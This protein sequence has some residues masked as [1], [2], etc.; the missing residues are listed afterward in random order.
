MLQNSSNMKVILMLSLLALA[1]AFVVQL[2]A[3]APVPLAYNSPWSVVPY[4]SYSVVQP[5]YVAK[6]PGAEHYAPLP[7]GLAYASHHI[8]I[9]PAAGTE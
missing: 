4:V 8:N 6:T 5:G 2:P 7:E 1:S 3:Q 9:R